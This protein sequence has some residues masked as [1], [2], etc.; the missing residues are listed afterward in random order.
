[1]SKV[2]DPLVELCTA[3]LV[4]PKFGTDQNIVWEH[5]DI[6]ATDLADTNRRLYFCPHCQKAWKI[7]HQ[8][9]GELPPYFLER[10]LAR[11]KPWVDPL[12]DPWDDPLGNG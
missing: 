9:L 2:S 5:P 11:E 6:E 10:Y 3:D 1:M 7:D 4:S 12:N 8:V